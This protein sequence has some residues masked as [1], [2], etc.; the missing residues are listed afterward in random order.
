MNVQTHKPFT[1]SESFHKMEMQPVVTAPLF[2]GAG[3]ALV[4]AFIGDTIEFTA[5]AIGFFVLLMVAGVL[6][7]MR[8]RHSYETK[9]IGLGADGFSTLN[10]NTPYETLARGNVEEHNWKF[11]IVSTH[12]RKKECARFILTEEQ[13]PDHFIKVGHEILPLKDRKPGEQSTPVTGVVHKLDPNAVAASRPS[14]EH[15]RQAIK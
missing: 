7:E 13:F 3:A 1:L 4:L 11:A 15:K 14:E 12:P 2:F 6:A 8:L 5:V 9:Y 10:K